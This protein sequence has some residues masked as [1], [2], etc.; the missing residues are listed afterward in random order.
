[1]LER[2]RSTASSRLPTCCGTYGHEAPSI[3]A[4]TTGSGPGIPGRPWT[5]VLS[6]DEL[7]RDL[8]LAPLVRPWRCGRAGVDRAPLAHAEAVAMQLPFTREQFLEVFAA[9]NATLWPGVLTLWMLSLL[10]AVLLFARSRRASGRVV[11]T[12]LA[13][14]WTWSAVAYHAAFVGVVDRSDRLVR[15]RWFSGIVVGRA[16]RL[17]TA[18]R[19]S[20]ARPV[21]RC[22]KAQARLVRRQA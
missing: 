17:R 16:R 9:Y 5:P 14:H 19:R 1:M 10:V 4:G 22:S 13:V 6:R 7:A 3:A 15:D 8:L 2:R 12:L 18:D 11:T 20:C 21:A